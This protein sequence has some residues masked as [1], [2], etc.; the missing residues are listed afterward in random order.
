[1]SQGIEASKSIFLPKSAGMKLDF[2]RK[3]DHQ[4]LVL[5]FTLTEPIL[6]SNDKIFASDSIQKP[7]LYS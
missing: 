3:V 1:M 7:I 6:V 2:F 5:S 4:P